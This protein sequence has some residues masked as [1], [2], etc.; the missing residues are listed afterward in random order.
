MVRPHGRSTQRTA[1]P[2]LA[3]ESRSD[4]TRRAERAKDTGEPADDELCRNI[5][6]RVS[7][8]VQS[9]LED[10]E[11]FVKSRRLHAS[12]VVALVVTLA[13]AAPWAQAPSSRAASSAASPGPAPASAVGLAGERL[14]L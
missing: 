11:A 10:L 7:W 14:D 5:N 13:L 12:T 1:E 4:R 3:V 8:L 2:A 9:R 6:G